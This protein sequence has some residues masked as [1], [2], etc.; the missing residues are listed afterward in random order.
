M[1]ITITKEICGQNIGPLDD[2]GEP[3]FGVCTN[4]PHTLTKGGFNGHSSPQL[5]AWRAEQTR[6]SRAKNKKPKAP[7]P[8]D[9]SIL[10]GGADAPGRD[11]DECACGHT[12]S[13]CPNPKTCGLSKTQIEERQKRATEE[14][15][16][17]ARRE[18]ARLRKTEEERF[19]SEVLGR[20]AQ[21]EAIDY[22]TQERFLATCISY[23]G[24]D[25]KFRLSRDERIA[26]GFNADG[27]NESRLS[28]VLYGP[29][30]TGLYRPVDKLDESS[31]PVRLGRFLNVADQHGSLNTPRH[32]DMKRKKED[33]P[34]ALPPLGLPP[35][36]TPGPPPGL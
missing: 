4:P 13:T 6:K 18:A 32:P 16:E 29:S 3:R 19:L 28:E 15:E 22:E 33:V 8:I 30:Y 31:F 12:F 11:E 26:R 35:V 24:V 1:E 21:G 34:V 5:K 10:D 17:A 2:L 7:A 9:D 14:A 27:I 25:K 36:F 20:H 23:L